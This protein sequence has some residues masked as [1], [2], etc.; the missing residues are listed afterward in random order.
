MTIQIAR[1]YLQSLKELR[2]GE[3]F[4]SEPIETDEASKDENQEADEEL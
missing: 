4:L 1:G 3:L 2:E